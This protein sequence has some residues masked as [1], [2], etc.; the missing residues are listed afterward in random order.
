MSCPIK[1][2]DFDDIYL[3]D[4]QRCVFMIRGNMSWPIEFE[5]SSDNYNLGGSTVGRI[6]LSGFDWAGLQSDLNSESDPEE[7]PWFSYAPYYVSPPP[8]PPRP[9]PPTA[10]KERSSKLDQEEQKK[11]NNNDEQSDTLCLICQEHK[12]TVDYGGCGHV[13]YCKPCSDRSVQ[14][15]SEAL[16]SRPRRRQE[17]K[18]VYNSHP[19]SYC[20]VCRHRPSI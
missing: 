4:K 16:C 2:H 7:Q 20:P 18:Q 15:L 9:S 3:I 12:A 14:L 13:V 17:I 6:D 5:E 19:L 8:P 11:L 1:S 10:Q